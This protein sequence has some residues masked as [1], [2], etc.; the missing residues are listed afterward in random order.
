MPPAAR[1]I[2]GRS[3]L[4]SATLSPIAVHAGMEA[5]RQGGTAADAAI[6]VA[7]TQ[8]ATNLGSVVS[9]AGIAELVYYDAR[10]HK[11]YALDAGWGSYAAEHDPGSI[12]KPDLSLLT[13][14]QAKSTSGAFGRETL[15]PGFMAGLQEAHRR[16][17]KL[18]FATLFEPA[19]WYARN[20]VTVSPLLGFYFGM[21]HDKLARTAEGRG[22]LAEA[23]EALPKV[24]D[25]F[26]QPE[27][28]NF[29]SQ[30][31]AHG[32]G[33]IY[34]GAWGRRFVEAVRREGGA[35][36]LDDLKHYRPVWEEPLSVA[37]GDAT[38]FGP[39]KTNQGSCAVLEALNL[40]DAAGT[41]KMGGYWSDPQAFTAYVKVLRFAQFGSY[42]PGPTG[43]ERAHG[44]ASTCEGRLAKSYAQVVAAAIDAASRGAA[45]ADPGH[46]SDAVVV[47]D[48][49][50]DVAALVHTNNSLMWGDTGI[51]VDGVP[52]PSAAGL[53]APRLA[54]ITPGEH[55]P[56]DMAPV[57]AVRQGRPVAAVAS[58]G[59]SLV[60]ETTRLVVGALTRPADLPALAAAP[61]L[62]LNVQPPSGG[63]L[64]AQPV[65]VPSSAYGA[66]FRT[67]VQ[68]SG[69]TLQDQPPGQ[70]AALR[71]TAAIGLI[72][73]G[74]DR[75]ATVETPGA[76]LFGD[77]R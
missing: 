10:T 3:E 72:D 46:H 75:V 68:A 29:L 7:L 63:D 20:G 47:V 74:R 24:G 38:V 16:F 37:F 17:G 9:Y 22:F 8:V 57:I 36:T 59:V 4:V 28:A 51:V 42:L 44:L 69:L 70:V 1:T 13:Q 31:A 52:I 66:E 65:L 39:G 55:V 76:I 45:P 60:Q 53:N 71:G 56:G 48:R 2:E 67:A 18:P 5:L 41:P 35:V 58:V 21:Q 25:R 23:G 32:A 43:F 33:Y 62:L 6:A 54:T 30:V 19:I 77:T 40:L 49:W 14:T 50:G 73:A 27:L 61:P 12:P 64:T 15:T 26:V 34:D 11:V